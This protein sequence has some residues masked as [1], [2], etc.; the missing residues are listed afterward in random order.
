MPV[1]TSPVVLGAVCKGRPSELRIPL[2]T[3]RLATFVRQTLEV[4]PEVRGRELRRTLST[5]GATL[6]VYVR[7][8]FSL[9]GHL[10][11]LNANRLRHGVTCSWLVSVMESASTKLLRT[12]IHGFLELVVLAVRTSAEFDPLAVAPAH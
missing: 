2:G 7:F 6:Q 8:G 12:A 4:D 5:D 11:G 3:E 10:F 9:G 1:L